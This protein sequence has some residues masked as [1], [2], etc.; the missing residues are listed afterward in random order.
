MAE[1]FFNVMATNFAKDVNPS[2]HSKKKRCTSRKLNP[3]S[4]KIRK[5]QSSLSLIVFFDFVLIF[6]S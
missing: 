4:T 2:I 6:I 1:K 3:S 5:L